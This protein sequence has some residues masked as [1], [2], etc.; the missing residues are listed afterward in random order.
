MG[1]FLNVTRCDLGHPSERHRC[2]S[3]LIPHRGDLIRGRFGFDVQLGALRLV[4]VSPQHWTVSR[5]MHSSRKDAWLDGHWAA[6]R[7]HD[8]LVELYLRREI[9]D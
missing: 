7:F 5:G 9:P 2:F 8:L 3:T 1:N 4:R 6:R